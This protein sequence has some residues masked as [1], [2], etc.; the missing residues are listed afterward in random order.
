MKIEEGKFYFLND[1][2]F[3][4]MKDNSTKGKESSISRYYKNKRNAIERIKRRTK[5]RVKQISDAN[6]LIKFLNL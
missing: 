2:F 3:E 1:S 4:K 6:D 5:S